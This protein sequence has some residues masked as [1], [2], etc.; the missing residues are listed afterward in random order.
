M[1]WLATLHSS[2]RLNA[3]IG[4]VAVALIGLAAIESILTFD[5][6]QGTFALTVAGVAILPAALADNPREM[7]PWPLLVV[8]ATAIVVQS[9]G[10]TSDAAGYVA[11]T[12]LA[13]TVVA[14]LETYT[15][16][17]MSRRFSIAFAAMT[18]MALEGI[19]TVARFY[20]DRWLG[21]TLLRSQRAL[22]WDFVLVTCIA[23]IVGALFQWYFERL[24]HIGF[25]SRPTLHEGG[26]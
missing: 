21:T 5:L 17:E 16:V 9:V 24:D 15:A 4:W 7:V 25:R 18:T 13:V 6:L 14:E 2:D 8:A 10:F 20:S 26:D 22:Q 11:I 23:V 3:A 19:W 1:V 12:T